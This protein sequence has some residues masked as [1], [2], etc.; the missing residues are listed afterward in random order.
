MSMLQTAADLI[1]CI[2]LP[3]I[4]TAVLNKSLY[5]S[6]LTYTSQTQNVNQQLKLC[7]NQL[8]GKSAEPVLSDEVLQSATSKNLI[9]STGDI[10]YADGWL[11]WQDMP[12][13]GQKFFSS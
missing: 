8:R 2:R 3:C 5:V 9:I 12:K 6:R 13:P 7:G 11:L 4:D 10:S 1:P